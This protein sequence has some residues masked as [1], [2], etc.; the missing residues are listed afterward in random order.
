MCI[1]DVGE[2]GLVVIAQSRL[3]QILG[4]GQSRLG[5]NLG[6]GA[7]QVVAVEVMPSLGCGQSRLRQV[8]VVAVEVV[9]VEV[10]VSGSRGCVVAPYNWTLSAASLV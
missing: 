4:C 7:L 10:V 9:A 8:Q 6:Y 3:W 5:Q 1:G 2:S